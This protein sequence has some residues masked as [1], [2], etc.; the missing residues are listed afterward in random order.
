MSSSRPRGLTN[1]VLAA[2][3]RSDETFDC[4]DTTFRVSAWGPRARGAVQRGVATARRLEAKLDA[5]SADSVLADLRATGRVVDEDVANVVVRA[6]SYLDRTA[7]RFDPR[8]GD[9]E[10]AVKAYVAGESDEVCVTFD[11][12][13]VRVSGSVVESAVRLDLNGLAKGYIVDRTAA[14]L[15]GTACRGFVDGGGDLSPPPGPVGIENPGG[16]DLLTV[17]DTDWAV[18]S[19]GGY[20]RGR[21]DVDHLYDPVGEH[22]GSRH[23][24]VTVVARRD[25]MEADALATTLSVTPLD[26]ALS[27]VAH[28]PGLEALVYRDGERYTTAGFDSHA[29]D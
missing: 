20:R 25:V 14:A 3:G 15:A 19:S 16:S 27:L 9:V 10:Q 6:L 18:A 5:F 26:D 28:W 2:V 1:R 24:Q 29:V 21:A 23:D 12:G 22:V 4:C 8:H 7:G 13:S 11:A 17:I